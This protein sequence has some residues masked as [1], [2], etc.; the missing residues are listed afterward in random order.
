[1][2]ALQGLGSATAVSIV[3]SF[4]L[5]GILGAGW[6]FAIGASIVLGLGIIAVVASR[7]TDDD[8]AADRAWA[9][10]AADLPPASDRRAMEEAQRVMPGPEKPRTAPRPDSRHG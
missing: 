1:M 8:L 5:V 6:P 4:F 2:R 7:A 10:A 3:F 9:A